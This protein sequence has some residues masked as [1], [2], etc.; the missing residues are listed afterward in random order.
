MLGRMETPVIPPDGARRKAHVQSVARAVAV[1][2]VLRDASEPLPALAVAHACGL[3]RTVVHRLLKTLV[4][5]GLALEDGG[6][7]RV[8]PATV[9]LANRYLADRSIRRVAV[10]YL[11]DLQTHAIGERPWT[12]TLSI[13]VGAVTTVIERIWSRATPLGFVLDV[14]DT[15]P[16]DDTAVG[17]C[18]L[19]YEPPERVA[20]LVGQ[21]RAAELA[22]VLA[23]IRA[24]AGVGLA[25][26]VAGA[27]V[28][29]VA[30]A[31]RSRRG[32]TLAG[33]AVAGADLGDELNVRSQLARSVR[34]A[35]DSIGRLV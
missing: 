18:L 11:V 30:A 34:R 27:T 21:T 35:A 15:F 1:L 32:E 16:I 19:A 28:E 3:D 13:P 23:E 4:V 29:A 10:P 26:N 20:G 14:G 24:N 31:I 5:T 12:V 22:D 17:R 7:Y 25:R 8:G 9:L 33:I 2:D 6:A